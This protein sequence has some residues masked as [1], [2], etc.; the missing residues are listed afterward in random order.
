MGV[1]IFEQQEPAQ[2]PKIGTIIG[3]SA[4]LN[5]YGVR[6]NWASVSNPRC[7]LFGAPASS[8]S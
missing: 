8:T 3:G 1:L 4:V 2:H 5:L 6:V 7:P